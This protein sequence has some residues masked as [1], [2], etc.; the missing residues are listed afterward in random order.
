[1]ALALRNSGHRGKG[2]GGVDQILQHCFRGTHVQV[3]QIVSISQQ[4]LR[5]PVLDVHPLIPSFSSSLI[6]SCT[7]SFTSWRKL[8]LP[9]ALGRSTVCGQKEYSDKLLQVK[10]QIPKDYAEQTGDGD[11]NALQG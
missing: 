9:E 7:H 3:W 6:H 2:L 5:V 1:M 8:Y 10:S 4:G 11:S